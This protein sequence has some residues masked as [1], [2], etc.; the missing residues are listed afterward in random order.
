MGHKILDNSWWYV[1]QL[2]VQNKRFQGFQ[3]RGFREWIFN[4]VVVKVLKYWFS[5]KKRIIS[6][7]RSK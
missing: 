7:I 2:V 4:T 1:S 6:E 3:I 5:G